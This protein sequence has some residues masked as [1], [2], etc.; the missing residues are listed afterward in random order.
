MVGEIVGE[1]KYKVAQAPYGYDT[2][3]ISIKEDKK[4]LIGEVIFD[5]GYKVKLQSVDFKNDTL[6]VGVYIDSEYINILSLVKGNTLEGTIDS[7]QG[8][9]N[10]I[11]ERSE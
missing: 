5:S 4:D 8:K 2:G 1:W 11:A 9:M 6:R 3:V 7:S 10:L